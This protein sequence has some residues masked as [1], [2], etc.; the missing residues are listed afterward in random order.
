MVY[1][2]DET[3]Y[4]VRCGTELTHVRGGWVCSKCRDINKYERVKTTR[5]NISFEIVGNIIIEAENI[6]D[7]RRKFDKKDIDELLQHANPIGIDD[8]FEIG[9]CTD[10]EELKQKIVD[11]I[12][13]RE[14]VGLS[15]LW[16][17]FHI[18]DD[19]SEEFSNLICE[20][21]KEGRIK[22]SE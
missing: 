9:M 12:N 18:D 17:V 22:E 20:L 6:D 21:I 13:P 16:E 1:H 15:D 8:I 19:K 4:C 11:Y 10:K 3:W 5:F 2:V 7:A 14:S